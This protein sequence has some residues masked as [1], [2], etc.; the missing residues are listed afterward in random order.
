MSIDPDREVGRFLERLGVS[1]LRSYPDFDMKGSLRLAIV[2]AH[3]IW[4]RIEDT[5]YTDHTLEHSLR[6]CGYCQQL[7]EN[8]YAHKVPPLS[9]PELVALAVASAI[10]DIGMQYRLISAQEAPAKKSLRETLYEDLGDLTPDQVRKSHVEIGR[11]LIQEAVKDDGIWPKAIPPPCLAD[12]RSRDFLHK[13]HLIAFAHS[14]GRLWDE[15]HS[16]GSPKFTMTKFREDLFRP[17]LLA[18]L[19][20]LADELDGSQLRLSKLERFSS[21]DVPPESQTHWLSCALVKEIIVT[22]SERA[23]EIQL[24]PVYPLESSG[25]LK[26]SAERFLSEFRISKIE[27]EIRKIN[28]MFEK[29]GEP[30]NRVDA[31]VSKRFPTAAQE[32]MLSEEVIAETIDRWTQS[33]QTMS[34]GDSK[35][36][37]DPMHSLPPLNGSCDDGAGEEAGGFV[38]C[39]LLENASTTAEILLPEP[40]NGDFRLDAPDIESAL[41][42]W[43]QS[44]RI[45][46]RVVL[47]TGAHTN[48]LLKCRSLISQLSLLSEMRR[49][50][51]DTVRPL[52][53]DCVVGVGTSTIPFAAHLAL[54][55]E[56]AATFTF[57]EKG[58]R[59]IRLEVAPVIPSGKGSILFVDDIISEGRTAMQILRDSLGWNGSE[60]LPYENVIWCSWFRLGSQGAV[61]HPQIK[62]YYFC[63]VPEVVYFKDRS[64]CGYC[65]TGN[66]CRPESRL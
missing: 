53:V 5:F 32:V 51:V 26:E 44:N 24:R 36:Q 34:A 31:T 25:A 8:G 22:G 4:E 3:S 65:S 54:E 13:C 62:Y 50:V 41:R 38:G 33:V 61:F 19:L 7:F 56:A 11:R 57:Y 16:S 17:R 15:C 39:Q 1:D 18:G 55:M 10:H 6:I 29:A 23:A 14:N 20:R 21:S 66:H 64:T 35:E 27:S 40:S 60:Q 48:I 28:A 9:I 12:P 59:H 49:V 42:D 47:E 43:Y 45:F 46:A 58:H 52:K 2:T 30:K 37:A 63:H